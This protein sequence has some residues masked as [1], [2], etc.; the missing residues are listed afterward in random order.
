MQSPK[1]GTSIH[2][3]VVAVLFIAKCETGPEKQN[4]ALNNMHGR[5][6][7]FSSGRL[8]IARKMLPGELCHADI[9]YGN[10]STNVCVNNVAYLIVGY[11]T[12]IKQFI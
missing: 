2:K 12:H 6:V 9:K 3:K 11:R 7:E 10:A 8:S 5:M 4:M 1:K